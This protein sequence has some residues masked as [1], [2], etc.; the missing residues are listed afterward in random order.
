MSLRLRNQKDPQKTLS[1]SCAAWF[2]LLEMAEEYGWNPMGTALPDPWPDVEPSIFG[3]DIYDA[4]PWQG[5]YTAEDGGLVILEDALNLGDALERAFLSYEPELEP[6]HI[7][8]DHFFA[9]PNDRGRS[10]Q[11]GVGVLN[12][13]MNFCWQGAF[14]IEKKE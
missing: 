6:A 2:S 4:L 3:F 7:F 14:W 5:G 1:M 8:A 12:E 9:G 13:V 11:H 10:R